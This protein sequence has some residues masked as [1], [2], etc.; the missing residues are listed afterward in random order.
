MKK[1]VY[2]LACSCLVAGVFV[3][4]GT[5]KKANASKGQ[6]TVTLSYSKSLKAPEDQ[7]LDLAVDKWLYH[8]L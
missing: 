1:V 4:C 3:S 8:H 2:L 7:S 5:Q 6:S